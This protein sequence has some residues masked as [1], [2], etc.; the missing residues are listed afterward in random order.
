MRSCEQAVGLS[1]QKAIDTKSGTSA[2]WRQQQQTQQAM[3]EALLV[4]VVMVVLNVLMAANAFK[5]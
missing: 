1:G 3:D 4:V 5:S 2:L